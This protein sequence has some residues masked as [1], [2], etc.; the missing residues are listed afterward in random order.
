MTDK[1][2]DVFKHDTLETGRA[3]GQ[4][5]VIREGFEAKI[6]CCTPEPRVFKQ[7]NGLAYELHR[8]SSCARRVC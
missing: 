6:G 1:N 5:R 8:S 7:S 4:V 3:H 2:V